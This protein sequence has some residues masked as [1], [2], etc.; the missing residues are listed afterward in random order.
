MD[1]NQ[2]HRINPCIQSVRDQVDKRTK[3]NQW[4]KDSVFNKWC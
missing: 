3:E 1:Q 2:E 4:G